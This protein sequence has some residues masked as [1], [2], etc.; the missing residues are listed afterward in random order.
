MLATK[1]STP[2]FMLAS[3]AALASAALVG[4]TGLPMPGM[5]VSSIPGIGVGT[6]AGTTDG[7]CM[8][9]AKLAPA[10][11]PAVPRPARARNLR[12]DRVLS[13]IGLSPRKRVRIIGILARRRPLT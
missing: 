10:V 13:G 1:V 4:E 9:A 6:V 12:R 8:Q 7:L 2:C 3:I 5:A 11:S